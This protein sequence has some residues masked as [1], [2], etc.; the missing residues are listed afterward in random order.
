MEN[1]DKYG[2]LLNSNIKLHRQYFREMVKLLGIIVLY[3]APLPNK[4][5]TNYAE[6]ES[7]YAPPLKIGCIFTDHPDQQTLK[8]MG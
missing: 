3:R 2:I 4:H 5:Y 6:I 8:K 1:L 7:N